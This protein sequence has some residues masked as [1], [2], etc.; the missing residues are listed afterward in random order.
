[1]IALLRAYLF[2]E[3][4]VHALNASAKAHSK[5]VFSHLTCNCVKPSWDEIRKTIVKLKNGKAA[6]AGNILAEELKVNIDTVEMLYPLFAR[7]REDEELPAT[8][9]K[10]I[11]LNFQR[12]AISVNGSVVSSQ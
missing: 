5:T 12:S 10:V 1:M 9:R 6:E 8:G 7:I 2:F 3:I 4:L 11:S